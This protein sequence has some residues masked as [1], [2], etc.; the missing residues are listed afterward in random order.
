MSVSSTST[1]ASRTEKS[2][3]VIRTV[4]GL[5]IV[6]MTT[7]SPA[8]MLRRVTTPSIGEVIVTW[9]RS[10][11]A[12]SSW[13][14]SCCTRCRAVPTSTVRAR[15]SVSRSSTSRRAWSYSSRDT[16][17]SSQSSCWRSSVSRARSRLT[18]AV[19]TA[20]RA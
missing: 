10:Y 2:A 19:S 8:S 9:V 6:P 14:R 4:P 17:R 1:W 5:F 16:R 7:V 15:S 3:I 18:R 11:S 13:A 12:L 20:T